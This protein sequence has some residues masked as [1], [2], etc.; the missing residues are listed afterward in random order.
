MKD[1]DSRG[2]AMRF[3][4]VEA[5]E[6]L[7]ESRSYKELSVV[8]ICH[9]AGIS[10]PTFYYHF[11][12]K[13][14][15]VQWHYDQ[16]CQTRLDESGRMLSWKQANLAN[17]SEIIKHKALYIAAF[18]YNKGYQ[19]LTAY[20]HRRLK[21]MLIDVIKEYNR[22]ALTEDLLLQ[23]DFFVYGTMNVFTR[24]GSDGMPGSANH[25]AEQIDSCL[26]PELEKLLRPSINKE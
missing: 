25:F 7:L 26:P 11:S 10:R 9:E 1:P 6:R 2:S 8:D 19:S 21:S 20:G 13:Y 5:A 23:I 17:I 24:W 12:D 16:I 14:E 15:I 4:I 18:R 22:E 3:K